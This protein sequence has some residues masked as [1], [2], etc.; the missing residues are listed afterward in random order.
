MSYDFLYIHLIGLFVISLSF[1]HIHVYTDVFNSQYFIFLSISVFTFLFI[2]TWMNIT[3]LSILFIYIYVYTDEFNWQY[4]IFVGVF[5]FLRIRTWMN[6][7]NLSIL[8]IHIHVYTDDSQCFLLFT[9]FIFLSISVFTF[10]RIRTWMNI[11]NKA[12]AQHLIQDCV[13]LARIE[14]CLFIHIYINMYSHVYILWISIYVYKYLSCIQN[15][16]RNN[17]NNQNL[18][19][20]YSYIQH[21]RVWKVTPRRPNVVYLCTYIMNTNIY[22]C[23]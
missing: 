11:T 22:M 16:Y 15:I 21:N 17:R 10:L 13:Q 9:I 23:I 6:I 14:V 3:N 20:L 1:L 4:F 7:T 5:T 8:F 2:R 18:Y 19:S 12:E